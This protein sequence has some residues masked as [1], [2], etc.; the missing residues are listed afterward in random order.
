MTMDPNEKQLIELHYLLDRF[1]ESEATQAE[2]DRIQEILSMDRSL[3]QYYFRYVELQSGLHQLKLLDS[4]CYSSAQEYKE[5]LAMLAEYEKNAPGIEFPKEVSPREL[6]QKVVYPP[7][8]KYK[9][10]RFSILTFIASAAAALLLIVLYLLPAQSRP[11][12]SITSNHKAVWDNL[13]MTDGSRLWNNGSIYHLQRGVAEVTFDSGAAVIVES[14]AEL[15]MINENEMF[16]RGRMTA[17]VPGSAYGFTVNTAN[18]TIVDLGTEFGITSD[19]NG[20]EVHVRKGTVEHMP[21]MDAGNSSKIILEVGQAS[22]A[23]NQGGFSRVRFESDSFRW[24]RPN[25]YEVTVIETEPVAYY[26]FERGVAALGFDDVSRTVTLSEC[27]APVDFVGGPAIDPEHR[28]Q[29]LRFTGE[30]GSGVFIADKVMELTKGEALTISMW[31]RLDPSEERGRNII[32][33]T[34]NSKYSYSNQISM[35][36][37]NRVRFYTH[38][39]TRERDVIETRT[40]VSLN[41][42]FH[43][44]ACYDK[45]QMS[46]YINGQLQASR[47]L[48]EDFSPEYQENGFWAIGVAGIRGVGRSA[49]ELLPFKGAIDELCFYDRRLSDGEV[50]MLYKA[51]GQ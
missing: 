34:N 4:A 39:V 23:D 38:S 49:K 7:R 15:E 1:F 6:I 3:Q 13:E 25:S 33:Y 42:W 48:T 47:H 5:E 50:E 35:T 20:T 30:T 8:E 16:L 40:P 45:E 2:V 32:H 22:R 27:P 9:L 19:E 21:A 10:N 31:V 24:E 29:S 51:A 28:N 44:A 26:R 46:V 18:S 11:V 43:I 17:K 37:D 41:Q 36:D 12:A 14:P